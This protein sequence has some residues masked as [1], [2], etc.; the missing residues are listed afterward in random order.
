[1]FKEML[2]QINAQEAAKS[3]K[4]DESD[5]FDDCK[6]THKEE[7]NGSVISVSCGLRNSQL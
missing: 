4:S 7:I 3:I 6:H 5:E 1:M 2:S